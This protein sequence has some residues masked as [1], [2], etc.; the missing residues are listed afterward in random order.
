MRERLH[1]S[2][3]NHIHLTNVQTCFVTAE[4]GEE[5]RIKPCYLFK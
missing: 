5:E 4:G 3:S 1:K 2:H